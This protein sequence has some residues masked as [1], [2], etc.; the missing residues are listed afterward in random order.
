[1]PTIAEAR[2]A[3]AAEFRELPE[4]FDRYAYLAA[5]APMLPPY[6]PEK[7]TDDRLVAGCQSKVWLDC[8]AEDGLF[9]FGARSDTLIINGVLYLLTQLLNGRPCAEV[10]AW[11][12]PALL[13]TFGLA[14]AFSDERQRGVGA[15]V[16]TLRARAAALAG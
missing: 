2:A 11:D 5:L 9:R 8:A 3:L 12:D 15:V 1:M 14:G 7:E 16:R 6:P 4:L 10:A 13:D